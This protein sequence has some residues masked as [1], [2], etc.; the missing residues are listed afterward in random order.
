MTKSTSKGLGPMTPSAYGGW[1]RSRARQRQV[2]K[3][4]AKRLSDSAWSI[5]SRMIAGILM[6]AGLGWLLSLWIG[7]QSVCIAVGALVGLGLSY[8]LIFSELSR[9]DS[10]DQ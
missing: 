8:Y 1:Y 5:S 10:K 3:D 2:T 4:D 9:E 6:Y 7:N